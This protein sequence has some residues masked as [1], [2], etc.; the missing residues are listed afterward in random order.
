[1]REFG[2]G[3][4]TCEVDPPTVELCHLGAAETPSR[5]ETFHQK[6]SSLDIASSGF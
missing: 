2:F 4:E 6:D 3:C 5:Q 1:M